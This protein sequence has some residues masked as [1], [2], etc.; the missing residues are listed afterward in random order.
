MQLAL[1]DA[2]AQRRH[3]PEPDLALAAH[4]DD[5]VAELA[6]EHVGHGVRIGDDRHGAV[7]LGALQQQPGVRR[8]S[9][10]RGQRGLEHKPPLRDEAVARREYAR[11]PWLIQVQAA[12][13]VSG[14]QPERLERHAF[15]VDAG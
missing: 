9:V 10:G 6:M 13:V 3:E 2:V 12:R 5:D 11:I 14:Q 8:L 15:Q 7:R 1:Q 4:H